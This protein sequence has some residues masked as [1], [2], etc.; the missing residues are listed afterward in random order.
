MHLT[1]AIPLSDSFIEKVEDVLNA[2]PVS[3]AIEI[4][5]P[6]VLVVTTPKLTKVKIKNCEILAVK[7]NIPQTK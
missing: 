7:T 5:N 6:S 3:D 2:S 1:T 4:L